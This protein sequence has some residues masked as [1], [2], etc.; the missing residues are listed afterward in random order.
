MTEQEASNAQDYLRPARMFVNAINA[1]IYTDQQST[2]SDGYSGN[3]PGQ[4]PGIGTG[5]IARPVAVTQGGGLV[6][7][8]TMV[9]V[10]LVFG[11]AL[12]IK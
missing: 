10:G 9:L 3:I 1:A 11:A 5:P 6:L 7:S 8:P 12:L 2:Y 4:Y